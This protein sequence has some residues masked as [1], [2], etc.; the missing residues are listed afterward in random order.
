MPPPMTKRE[1]I[2]AQLAEYAREAR[3]QQHRTREQRR[4]QLWTV[5]MSGV[6]REEI[7]SR[8]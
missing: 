6:P 1:W 5:V 8:H 2:G 4:L 3:F 7:G